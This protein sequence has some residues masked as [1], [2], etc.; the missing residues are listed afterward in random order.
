MWWL[1]V[2]GLAECVAQ[3]SGDGDS[4]ID[5]AAVIEP[6]VILDDSQGA[7]VIG[8][9]TKVCT[10]AV[11]RGPLVIGSNGLIGNNCMVRGPTLIG[12]EVRIGFASE[13]KQAMIADRV[14]IGPQC[15]V[16]DSKI[17]EGAYLGAQV[18]TSNQRLDRA[19]IT[20]R[21]GEREIATNADKLGCWIGARSALGI[22]ATAVGGGVTV[23]Q[24]WSSTFSTRTAAFVAEN[25]PVFA[26]LGFAQDVTI[27]VADKTTVT[28]GGRWARYFGN[29]DVTFLSAGA[30]RYFR[31]GSVSYRLTHVNPEG[32]DAFLAHLVNITIDDAS[33]EGKTQLWLST[34]EASLD[35]SQID[36]DFDGQNRAAMLQRTQ[37]LTSNLALVA[38]AG[39]SSFDRPQGDFTSLNLGLGVLVNTR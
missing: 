39:L 24:D 15:F 31:G 3:A 27:A 25:E 18:R 19:A 14:M 28:L 23:Y 20:V 13:I 37:P 9:G 2:L 5:P 16:S 6:G 33:G 21:D 38:S 11:L 8:P 29:Q 36:G 17:D 22:S 1:E 10:G 30:R 34:G 32:R 7:I 4:R 35:R 12:D 26:E